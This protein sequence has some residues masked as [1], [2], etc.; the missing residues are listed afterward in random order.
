VLDLL[1][2]PQRN[3]EGLSIEDLKWLIQYENKA[4]VVNVSSRNVVFGLLDTIDN[5]GNTFVLVKAANGKYIPI[6]IK[7]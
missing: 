5:V 7:P 3:P 4:A 1:N 2:D 6:Y